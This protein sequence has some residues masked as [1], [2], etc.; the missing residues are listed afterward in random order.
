MDAEQINKKHVQTQTTSIGALKPPLKRNHK[1]NGAKS[2]PPEWEAFF[3]LPIHEL[4]PQGGGQ[5]GHL[6]QLLGDGVDHLCLSRPSTHKHTHTHINMH[7]RGQISAHNNSGDSLLGIYCTAGGAAPFPPPPVSTRVHGE[8]ML[9]YPYKGTQHLSVSPP[10]SS[11]PCS[12]LTTPHLGRKPRG[13]S[14][15]VVHLERLRMFPLLSPPVINTHTDTTHTLENNKQTRKCDAMNKIKKK[16][17]KSARTKKMHMY[18]HITCCAAH[19][20]PDGPRLTA[21]TTII[22]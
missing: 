11:L 3:V 9:K 7:E 20:P 12:L 4:L 1:C 5:I 13:P 2:H 18:Y 21:K 15:V 16:N 19:H 6:L 22:T 10:P 17:E 14:R 8:Q